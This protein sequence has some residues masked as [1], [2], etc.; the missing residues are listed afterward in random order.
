MCLADA[1]LERILFAKM[2][3]ASLFE[4]LNPAFARAP[5]VRFS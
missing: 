3:T 4:V 5:K 2:D 1:I